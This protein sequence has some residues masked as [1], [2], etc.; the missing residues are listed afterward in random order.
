MFIQPENPN[1]DWDKLSRDPGITNELVDSIQ[2]Y[3]WNWSLL[4]K[5]ESY[6]GKSPWKWAHLACKP[7]VT[8]GIIEA[9]SDKEEL[10]HWNHWEP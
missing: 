10:F 6:T 3:P 7:T 4:S 1:W 8:W 5:N 9:N 2:Y